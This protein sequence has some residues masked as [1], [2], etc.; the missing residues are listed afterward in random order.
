M[1]SIK[2]YLVRTVKTIALPVMLYAVLAIIRPDI[3]LQWNTFKLIIIQSIPNLLIGWSMFSGMTVGLFD[4]SVGSRMILAGLVGVNMAIYFGLPGFIIGTLLAS[5]IIALLTGTIY[6]ALKIPSIITGFAAL[7]IFEAVSVLYMGTFSN[8]VPDS[9]R[10]FGREPGIYIVTAVMFVL[11]YVTQYKTKFGYQIM[12]I[13]GNE[14]IARSMGINSTRLKLG[15]FL[16]GGL[17]LG[18]AVLVQVGYTGQVIIYNNMLSLSLVFIPMMG[19]IIG[20]FIKSCNGVIG[21]FIGSL[22]ITIIGSGI[23]ALGINTKLQNVIV[24]IFLLIFIG[25]Q[26]NFENIKKIFRR[27]TVKLN[28]EGN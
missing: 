8:V 26:L 27:S 21:T 14:A 6:A 4:F 9:V 10:V 11:V 2:S 17:F 5:L 15:T 12:A 7:L 19:V 18:V 28:N 20:M 23:A 16:L 13:G 1:K 22:T 25:M 24:G 3:F